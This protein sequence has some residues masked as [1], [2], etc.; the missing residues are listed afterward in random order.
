MRI[1]DQHNAKNYV[2]QHV[3]FMPMNLAPWIPVRLVGVIRL[4]VGV[5][6]AVLTGKQLDLLHYRR[7]PSHA[8]TTYYV[9]FPTLRE[10]L[11]KD[12]IMLLDYAL[13]AADVV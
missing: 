13:E 10:M 9:T 4:D 12:R 1:I 6:Q 8:P 2:G 5:W 7:T 3:M 11:T